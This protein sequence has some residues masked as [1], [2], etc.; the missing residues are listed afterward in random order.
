VAAGGLG[1]SQRVARLGA[2]AVLRDGDAAAPGWA[3]GSLSG[4]VSSVRLVLG[5]SLALQAG[6]EGW[7]DL[8]AVSGD[9]AQLPGGAAWPTES[10]SIGVAQPTGGSS[11]NP[12]R[13]LRW[14]GTLGDVRLLGWVDNEQQAST[15]SDRL[16]Y[17]LMYPRYMAP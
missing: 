10:T 3:L 2:G 14:S 17:A 9:L 4:S 6:S 11:A 1:G 5:S 16:G 15:P 8:W 12:S 13:Q 7:N